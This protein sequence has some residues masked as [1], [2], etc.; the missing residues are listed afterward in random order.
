MGAWERVST[1]CSC[2]HC[3]CQPIYAHEPALTHRVHV[4]RIAVRLAQVVQWRGRVAV[5]LDSG[6]SMEGEGVGKDTERDCVQVYP[7]FPTL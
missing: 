2:L 7:F 3:G 5:L 1:S 4:E 6:C